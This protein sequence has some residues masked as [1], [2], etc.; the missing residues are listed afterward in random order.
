MRM[1]SETIVEP[2]GLNQRRRNYRKD[3]NRVEMKTGPLLPVEVKREQMETILERGER[4]CLQEEEE[5]RH[6]YTRNSSSLTP[7]WSVLVNKMV[8]VGSPCCGP[9]TRVRSHSARAR[10][11]V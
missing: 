3:K 7:P 2:R 5:M 10:Y 6:G 9:R 4:R 1:R 8:W 11:H